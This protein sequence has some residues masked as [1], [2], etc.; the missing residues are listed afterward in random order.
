MSR[1]STGLAGTAPRGG[2][3]SC[4]QRANR[5]VVVTDRFREQFGTLL[6]ACELRPAMIGA[7][8]DGFGAERRR[9]LDVEEPIL[10][11]FYVKR[12]IVSPFDGSTK[13]FIAEEPW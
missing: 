3:P 9:V 6:R 5:R 13:K 12:R 1:E 10:A 4:P 11:G 7:I 2:L 8:P